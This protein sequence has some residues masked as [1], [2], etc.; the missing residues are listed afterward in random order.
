MVLTLIGISAGIMS[1]VTG[2]FALFGVAM[3]VWKK[4]R[5]KKQQPT[6]FLFLAL[7]SWAVMC[8][9]ASIV[10]F[11]A[12]YSKELAMLFQRLIYS[13]TVAGVIFLFLFASEIF[14][15]LKKLWKQVYG[16]IG[17]IIIA[18]LLL[19]DSSYPQ[20]LEPGTDY[21]VILIKE[22]FGI[23]LLMYLFPTF[24]GIYITAQRTSQKVDNPL[25][26]AG[27]IYIAYG[28]IFGLLT[29][30]VDTLG[31]FV[32]S[33][34]IFYTICL[35]LTWILLIFA[36][37]FYYIGWILPPGFRRRIELQEEAKK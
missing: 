36:M 12:G 15:Q 2:I 23:A 9:S 7:C 3:K 10:Y 21:Y 4:Y 28:Q 37:W 32:I 31:T 19:I 13:G 33:N 16:I 34:L 17:L 27:Y 22:E 6:L 30:G 25:Y 11:S 8:W 24:I 29:M 26:R 1:S 35:N 18:L 14:F 20:E 5:E